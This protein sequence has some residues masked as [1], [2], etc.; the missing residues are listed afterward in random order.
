MKEPNWRRYLRFFGPRGAADL[1][2]E[3]RFHHEMRVRDYIA[4]GMAEHDARAAADQRLGDVAA[5]RAACATVINRS[6]RRSARARVF[7]ALAQDVSF[8][9]RTLGRNKAWTAVAV[10]TLALGIGGNSAMFSVIHHLILNPLPYPDADRVVLVYQQPSQRNNTGIQIT[11]TPSGRVASAWRQHASAFETIEAYRTTDVTIQRAGDAA[12]TASSASVVPTFPAFT[13]RQPL[14]G[15]S[16][17]EAETQGGAGV[18]MI[19]EGLWRSQYA[20]DARVLGQTL[21]VNDQPRVIVGV[22]PGAFR[23]PRHTSGDIDVWLP[24]DLARSDFDGLQVVGRLR[25]GVSRAAAARE[26]DAIAGRDEVR[27]SDNSRHTT[28]LASPAELL[29]YGDALWMLTGAVGLV[30][31]IACANVAHLLLA[32][33][34]TRQ[35][36][37][38]IRTALGAGTGRLFRQLLTESLILSLA[39]CVAGLAL[40][41]AGLRALI[42]SRP[43]GLAEL[44]VV[45]MNATTIVVTILL[46]LF[47]GVA[48]GTI[49]AVQAARHSANEA[50][51]TGSLTASTGRSRGRT[52]G[53]LVVTEMAVCTLLVVGAT[54][55]LRSVRHL[56]SLDAG[57]DARGLYALELNLPESRYSRAGSRTGS[58]T[59]AFYDE[60][61]TRA[62]ALPGVE[63]IT[64]TSASPASSSFLIGA[65]QIEGQPM[66]DAGTTSFINVTAVG[67]EYFRLMRI[68]L[69]EGT[70]FTDTAA[71]GNQA[72]VNEGLA[73]RYWPG[74]S[75]IGKRLRVVRNGQGDW[76]TVVAVAAN[77]LTRGLTHDGSQPMLYL[78]GTSHFRPSLLVRTSGDATMLPVLASLATNIDSRLPP[79]TIVDVEDAMQRTIAQPRFTMFLLLI[80]TAVA[81]ALA[82]IGLYGVL[83]YS[84][85]QRTREIGIRIALGASRRLV[86]RSVLTHGLTLAVVGAAIG[87]VAARWGVALLSSF[88]YGVAA[89]DAVSFG[90]SAVVILGVA[91]AACLVPTRRAVSVDP[92][93][94]MRAD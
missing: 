2:D 76:K 41:W 74:Q 39:G 19:S 55:L 1:D 31:L 12:R 75:P 3:L 37:M 22:M 7:D 9:F 56:Q 26:L 78:P 30:L 57:F 59:A 34:S 48:F 87:L 17:T 70:T 60:L 28:V 72:I 47:T 67:A 24:L 16:F 82:A 58:A 5:A 63:G 84:V 44:S 52:R 49:G 11:I 42:A 66:P 79:T 32:R 27:G 15:R 38:A 77:V 13:G 21:T 68:R 89:T 46:S 53:L 86:A 45:Q 62:R 65:L 69:V 73:R 81:V 83:A 50:L 18:V 64:R 51:K 8:A 14:L 90:L 54:L 94:A 35:R 10:L 43:E 80:F 92:L 36:E 40:A 29:D 6:E 88:L 85:A 71:A 91:A 4:Q 25:A 61:I 20:G 23:L 33:A 93:I